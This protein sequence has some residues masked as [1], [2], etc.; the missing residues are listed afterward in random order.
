V[1][2][3]VQNVI[4]LIIKRFWGEEVGTV[5][6]EFEV[7]KQKWEGCNG[8]SQIKHQP[9]ENIYTPKLRKEQRNRKSKESRSLGKKKKGGGGPGYSDESHLVDDSHSK[10]KVWGTSQKVDPKRMTQ[11]Q[12][13][14]PLSFIASGK[15]SAQRANKR[16]IRAPIIRKQQESEPHTHPSVEIRPEKPNPPLFQ[17]NKESNL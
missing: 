4:F 15:N 11:Y 14:P 13:V 8:I 2:L 7:S 1:Q 12:P 16:P 3:D 10:V 6:R 17:R 5:G 9:E